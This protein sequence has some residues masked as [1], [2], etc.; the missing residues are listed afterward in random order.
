MTDICGHYTS[1]THC[2]IITTSG[3]LGI[4]W[5]VGLNDIDYCYVVFHSQSIK[6]P[7]IILFL[8]IICNL[9]SPNIYQY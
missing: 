5:K 6:S 4:H 7:L 8:F 9:Q 2:C 3:L 1:N